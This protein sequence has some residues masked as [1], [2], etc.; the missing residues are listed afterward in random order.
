MWSFLLILGSL[1][2][3]RLHVSGT[4]KR[5]VSWSIGFKDAEHITAGAI[6][7][8]AAAYMLGV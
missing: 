3:F 4:T 8:V 1:M 2:L 7:V 6:L 5:G